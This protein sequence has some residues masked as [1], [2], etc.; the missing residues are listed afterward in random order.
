MIKA[1]FIIVRP[2]NVVISMMSVYLGG[3]ISFDKYYSNDLLLAC[4]SAGLIAGFGNLCNDI[5]DI[6][7]DRKSKPF[8]PLP[9]S[10]ITIKS[11]I[12]LAVVL[13]LFGLVSAALINR[14]CL[15]I[16]SIT[17]I[18][19]L[20]YTPFFK[21]RGY[22]GNIL[23]SLISAMAFFYGAAAT[24]NIIGGLIPAVFA[25]L[26]HF[27]REIIKDMEDYEADKAYNVQTGAV[28]YGFKVSRGYA[29]GLLMMIIIAT[30]MPYLM[31]IYGL[32]YLIIVLLGTDI[33]L[34][35][36][37]VRLYCHPNKQTYRFI[38]AV[39]KAVMPLGILAVFA[40]SRGF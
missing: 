17:A 11:A 36:F 34:L 14:P 28:R 31:E 2:V 40:G 21:G 12:V 15:L 22:S 32:G 16:A 23:I 3:V 1:I 7:I 30:L 25:F 13:S 29:I 8:R 27:I 19:L 4:F 39:M 37:I 10:Q 9:S 38:S 35:Y 20:F 33:F 26:F 24:G 5:F 6:E 18:A